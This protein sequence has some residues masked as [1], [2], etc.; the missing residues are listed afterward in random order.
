MPTRF[1]KMYEY[2]IC[3]RHMERYQ[4]DGKWRPAVDIIELE[5]E[6]VIAADV[7]GVDKGDI[8][9]LPLKDTLTIRGFRREF[10]PERIKFYYRMEAV[11]GEFERVFTFPGN[12]KP[13]KANVTLD[14]G[15]L[16]ITLKKKREKTK[17]IRKIE[18]TV[19]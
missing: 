2:M 17:V 14:N 5:D 8:E 4:P 9:I 11:R 3:S 10:E 7:P 12:I 18:I 13:S 1:E 6:I 19:R 15:V 16:Y